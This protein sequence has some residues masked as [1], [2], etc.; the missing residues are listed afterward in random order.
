MSR[1]QGGH[2]RLELARDAAR[3]ALW[4]AESN[5]RVSLIALGH[6]AR[7]INPEPTSNL[8]DI[9]R[10][11]DRL[12]VIGGE[13]DVSVGLDAAKGIFENA[14]PGPRELYFVTDR[15]VFNWENIKAEGANLQWLKDSKIPARF[16][17]V[18]VGGRDADSLTIQPID[19]SDAVFVRG[20]PQ[21]L[22]IRV[23][24]NSVNPR[25]GVDLSLMTLSSSDA[26]AR[27][28][29]MKKIAS[30]KIDLPA[31]GTGS[32]KI[33]LTLEETGS[34]VLSVRIE[35]SPLETGSRRDFAVEV[36]P[37][38]QTLILSGD[39]PREGDKAA[40]YFRYALA[41]RKSL[42]MRGD[43]AEVAEVSIDQVDGVDF[44][45]YSVIVLSNPPLVDD[46]LA[47]RLEQAV[48]RG[49]GVILCPGNLTRVENFNQKL[50]RYDSGLSPAQLKA[51]AEGAATL[52]GL[53][54]QDPVF[55]FIKPGDVLPGSVFYR[56]FSTTLGVDSR[57]L[58]TLSTGEP[59]LLERSL[60]RGKAMLLT[61]PPDARWNQLHRNSFFLPLVQSM[62]RVLA[63]ASAPKRNLT[64]GDSIE[65]NFDEPL[66][67][68]MVIRDDDPPMM[69]Q[70]RV[71]Q[72]R[73]AE[74][75]QPGIYRVLSLN[76][77]Q[78]KTSHY[79]V[80]DS[81]RE[82]DPAAIDDAR[83]ASARKD[84][85]FVELDPMA[86]AIGPILGVDRRGRE[87]WLYFLVL[88]SALGILEQVLTRKWSGEV[89]S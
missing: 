29:E 26:R 59:L 63:A 51:P 35:S 36:I 16:Y 25:A 37:P 61:S 27:V 41:P 8:Q 69:N 22:E 81:P 28:S 82:S 49:A 7:V 11:L 43:P 55:G 75:F 68:V 80:G 83:W 77:G 48:Y 23:R 38:I 20:V 47:S 54:L 87:L 56:S 5:A 3:Q 76:R 73:V 70:T 89:E 79:V 85:G 2:S 78:L 40:D 24:N 65:V 19:A 21:T 39:D 45:K 15:Q 14:E 53:N 74:A 64:I 52:L 88:S 50:W 18:P 12:S 42:G 6:E 13:A 86:E 34:K 33:P 30:A 31:S 9:A 17:V 72:V 46:V 71:S 67:R 32:A 44:S 4:S 58:A 62:A 66:D 1:R 57:V 10:E 60:G 84:L